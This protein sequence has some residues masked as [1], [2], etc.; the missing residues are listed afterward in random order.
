MTEPKGD[1]RIRLRVVSDWIKSV[2]KVLEIS[3]YEL[4]RQTGIK[5]ER[6][7]TWSTGRVHPAES[8]YRAVMD[9]GRRAQKQLPELPP[10]QLSQR[11]RLPANL[12]SPVGWGAP[13]DGTRASPGGSLAPLEE[14]MLKHFRSLSE[15]EQLEEITNLAKMVLAKQQTGKK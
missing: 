4:A 13:P 8:D 10:D 6:I 9:L 2:L 3:T 5:R 1:P 12:R 15:V 7:A 14:M 11:R